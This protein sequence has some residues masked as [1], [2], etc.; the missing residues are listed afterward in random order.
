MKSTLHLLSRL[1]SAGVVSATLLG[2]VHAA[3]WRASQPPGRPGSDAYN[4]WLN[5]AME[6][7]QRLSDEDALRQLTYRY[8]RGNDEIAFHHGDRAKGRQLAIAEYSQAFTPDIQIQVFALQGE[9]PLGSTVG[10]PAWAEFVEKFYTGYN[11]STTIHLM[12]NFSIEFIDADTARVSAYAIAPH[13]LRAAAAKDRA[14]ADT[15]LEV[16]HCK[17]LH[18]A[19]RQADGSWKTTNLRIELQE[20]W[21]GVGFFPAGQGPGR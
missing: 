5:A 10:I 16:M 1:V 12:S 8:G 18:T 7:L 19:K 11:Y 17:Y 2:S 4:R 13:F 20:M 9:Q 3:E 6:R 14:T 15:S 21:R